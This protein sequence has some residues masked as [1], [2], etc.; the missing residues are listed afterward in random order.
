MRILK[1]KNHFG[2]F[3]EKQTSMKIKELTR[4]I[5]INYAKICEKEGSI[6]GRDGYGKLQIQLFGLNNEIWR[7]VSYR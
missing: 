4:M 7:K 2:E 6:K 1:N 5:K 3:I